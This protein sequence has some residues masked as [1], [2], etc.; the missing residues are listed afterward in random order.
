MQFQQY[1][2][3]GRRRGQPETL[4]VALLAEEAS[5]FSH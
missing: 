1:A 2:V 3:R 5:I 4:L